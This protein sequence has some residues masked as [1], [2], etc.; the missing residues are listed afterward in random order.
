MS[1]QASPGDAGATPRRTSLWQ[2]ALVVLALGAFSFFVL[3]PS[4]LFVFLLLATWGMVR[5]AQVLERLGALAP[6]FFEGTMTLALV[7]VSL[8]LAFTALAEG[9]KLLRRLAEAQG[10]PSLLLRWPWWLFGLG[11]MLACWL[12]AAR[13]K[14][15]MP[16]LSGGLVLSLMTWIVLTQVGMFIQLCLGGLSLSWRLARASPFGAGLLTV[17]GVG[18]AIF[19]LTIF[20]LV[21][22][23]LESQARTLREPRSTLACNELTAECTRQFLL[24]TTGT[25]P[26]PVGSRQTAALAGASASAWGVPEA[27]S[28]GRGPSQLEPARSRRVRDCLET[29]YKD[30]QMMEQAR[31]IAEMHVGTEDAWDIVHATLLSVCLQGRDY[32]DFRQFFL[33]S[34]RN[35]SYRWVERHVM[36]TCPFGDVPEPACDLRPDDDYLR[37]EALR[38][39]R[40]SLCSLKDDDREVL[41]LRYFDGLNEQEIAYRLGISYDAARKR[42]QR[43]RDKLEVEFLQQCQ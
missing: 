19:V 22:E 18:S 42:L 12:V 34:I 36:R 11:L 20:G 3:L 6:G 14:G 7:L 43:A 40:T 27:S 21:A 9:W 31:F 10:K 16:I 26:V 41:Y 8:G 29:H 17:G 38:A 37:E 23:G 13:V 4:G 5:S 39:L 28:D 30:R 32:Y 24:A 35:G 2:L 15:S 25:Q 1:Q 33:R